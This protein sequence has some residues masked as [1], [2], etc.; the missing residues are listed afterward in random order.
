MVIV[1][2]VKYG[3]GSSSGYDMKVNG[4]TETSCSQGLVDQGVA[5][6]HTSV[7]AYLPKVGGTRLILRGFRKLGFL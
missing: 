1:S 6:C 5:T 3:Y 2:Q 4:R 7:V